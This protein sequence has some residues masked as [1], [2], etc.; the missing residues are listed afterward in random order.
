MRVKLSIYSPAH[1]IS[2]QMKGILTSFHIFKVPVTGN[3]ATNQ[4]PAF[5]M[6][7]LAPRETKWFVQDHTSTSWKTK[8][9]VKFS[10]I[11]MQRSF[12]SLFK[13]N[14]QVSGRISDS[15]GEKKPLSSF[16]ERTDV[17]I[18]IT[19]AHTECQQ[20]KVA[21]FFLES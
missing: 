10:W 20:R 17:Q 1:S 21:S 14:K 5:Q 13:F 19:D 8:F 2:S 6:R 18:S 16:N 7:K 4:P 15:L 3:Y 12:F 11:L 9:R